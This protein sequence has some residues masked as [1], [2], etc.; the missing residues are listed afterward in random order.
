MLGFALAHS[1]DGNALPHLEE[2]ALT[3]WLKNV[4]SL[5]NRL[6]LP[7]KISKFSE[8][9]IASY[10]HALAFSGNDSDNQAYHIALLI[11]MSKADKDRSQL[12]NLLRLFIIYG[13]SIDEDEFE[14]AIDAYSHV[15]IIDIDASLKGAEIGEA[16]WQKRIE[17]IE[18]SLN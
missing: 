14:K 13:L 3:D 15:T 12:L 5:S 6:K 8:L 17:S 4:K 18:H 16:L 11:Q 10:P 2:S 7:N 9:V 1:T